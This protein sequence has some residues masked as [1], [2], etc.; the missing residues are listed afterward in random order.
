MAKK[1]N[2]EVN[3]SKYFR[4]TRTVG[5]KAD[6]TPIRKTFYGS[7]I[8]EANEKADE[9]MNKLK[10]GYSN[11]FD[12]VILID[13]MQKWLFSVKLVAVKPATFT[14]YE[15][16]FRNHIVNSTIAGMK[17]CDIKKIHIQDY[18]NKLFAEGKTTEKIKAIHKLLHS[19]FEY[20]VEEGYLHKNPAHNT[21]IPKNN[22][23]KSDIKKIDCFSPQE[24]KDI[25][26]AFKGHKFEP[27]IATAI[28][29]G[30]REGELLALKWK[31][32]NLDEGYI[33]VEE[34][35]SRTAVFNSDGTKE[36]KM[37]TL[38]PKTQKS[39]RNIYIPD[40][41]IKVIKNIPK[42]S[43]YVFT[44]NNEPITHK[45]LYFQ[46][47]KILKENNIP[48]KKFHALRHTYA[49]TLLANGADIKSVQDLMGH[50]DISITQVYLH[51]L[52]E[53]KKNVVSIFDNL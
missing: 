22:L 25:L 36:Y 34:S 30:M 20:A 52:P 31:N 37:L 1:T 29:T 35:I 2:F 33:K 23:V 12:K 39:L 42:T 5:H 15:C 21:I 24:I 38:D 27:L 32:I 53:T 28:Y 18:Y 9:Y 44:N 26:I 7:G 10:N 45:S 3:G 13:V 19:F 11:D 49:S 41:L 17:V 16:N 43:E 50:H 6:G 47:Q 40:V 48:H 4:V 14:T 51:S 8:N 46:W